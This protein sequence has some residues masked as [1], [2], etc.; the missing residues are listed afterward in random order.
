MM[1][2]KTANMATKT[3]KAPTPLQHIRELLDH[4]HPNEALNF[5]TRSGNDS[6]EMENARGVCLLRLGRFDEAIKV[7]REVAFQG[8][9]VIP[10]DVPALFQ[11]NFA[12]AMLRANRDKGAALMISDRLQGSEHPEAARLKAAVRQW[13][14]SLG[15]LGRLRCRL[16]LYPAQPVPLDEHAGAV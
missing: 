1:A 9:P 15:P 2:T 11:A 5:I 6:P 4:D 3:A 10:H 7:L 13:K 16:G 14:E 12:V 8:L